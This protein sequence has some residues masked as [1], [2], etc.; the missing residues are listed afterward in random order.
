[1]KRYIRANTEH[2]KLERVLTQWRELGD[3]TGIVFTILSE[4][5]ELLFEEL[6]DYVDVD[7][8]AIYDSAVD[9]ARLALS[10]KYDLS[11]EVID[12]IREGTI[13]V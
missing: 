7:D 12:T 5:N 9:L 1:M 4:D 11:D 6:F 3:H 13:N 2:P 10:Q 8:D